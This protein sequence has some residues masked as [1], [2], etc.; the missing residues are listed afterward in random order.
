MKNNTFEG[1]DALTILDLEGNQIREVS[2][3]ALTGMPKLQ[4]LSFAGNGLENLQ[5]DVLKTACR[6][7]AVAVFT[8]K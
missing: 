7:S 3:N 8:G 4:Q 1:L 5:D 2:Q 6:I